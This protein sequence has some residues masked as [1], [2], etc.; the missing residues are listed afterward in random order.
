MAHTVS[1]L[2]VERHFTD[3]GTDPYAKLEWVKRDSLIT[4][5]KTGDIVFEQ[6]DVE[7]PVF[8]SQNAI[9]IVTQKYFYGMPGTKGR[10]TGLKDLINRVANTITKFGYEQGYFLNADEADVFNDEL[11]Y[12][13]A[14]Q[15]AAFNSPVWFNIGTADRCLLYTSPSPRDS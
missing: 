7:F 13:L 2:A 6:K 10:E 12:I 9:N 8:W 14:T 5:P 1:T 3:Q 11:K 15:K 4:N